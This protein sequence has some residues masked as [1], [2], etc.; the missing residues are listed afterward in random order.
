MTLFHIFF[1]FTLIITGIIF[2]AFLYYFLRP[3]S[4]ATLLKIS[5]VAF[6]AI[7]FFLTF[8]F[9]IKNTYLVS[10]TD[11]DI[12]YQEGGEEELRLEK[13]ILFND[14]NIMLSVWLIKYHSKSPTVILS[15][16]W[17]GSKL[18]VLNI[19]KSLYGKGYNCLLFDF[20]AHGESKGTITSFGYREQ[21]DLETVID[22]ILSNSSFK[23]KKIGLYGIS[24]GAA[25]SILVSKKYREIDV[26][27]AD[28]CYH[29]L[30]DNLEKY[31]NLKYNAPAW[32][33]KYPIR[34]AYSARFF[35]DPQKISCLETVKKFYSRAV[36]FINSENDTLTPSKYAK[37]LYDNTNSPKKLWIMQRPLHSEKPIRTQK[38]YINEV[39]N[40]FD[41]HLSKRILWKGLE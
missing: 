1:I 6:F 41:K 8:T 3:Q 10:E 4:F 23:N 36:F 12:E 39:T 18:D 28:S 24:M 5:F 26:I 34:L 35:K 7:P 22:Y 20:R 27:V 9:L 31:A 13:I 40:F 21:K 2:L 33:F 19:A 32:L 25:V 15:H 30:Q 38:I 16:G 29:T 17:K 37:K 11:Y 14:D